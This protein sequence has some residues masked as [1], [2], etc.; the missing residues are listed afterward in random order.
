MHARAVLM[1]VLGY[2]SMSEEVNINRVEHHSLCDW[3]D[4]VYT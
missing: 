4:P 3:E 1:R 2:V